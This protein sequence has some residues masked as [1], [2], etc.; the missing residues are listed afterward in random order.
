MNKMALQATLH[1]LLGCAIGE[2]AGMMIGSYYG[3]G[4]MPTIAL[5]VTLAFISGYAL[6]I[7]PLVRNGVKATK[8]LKLVFAADTLSITTMEIVDNLVM[9]L[10]PGAM[11]ANLTNWHFYGDRT[12]RSILGSVSCQQIPT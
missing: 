5:A 4:T 8:A 6:S 1:C 9:V 7:V 3:L 2:V 11:S 12:F 10:I